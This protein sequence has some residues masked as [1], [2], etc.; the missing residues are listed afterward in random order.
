MSKK[1]GANKD[2]L[3]H[4]HKIFLKLGRK[5]FANHGYAGAST[6][7]IVEA[8]GMARGSLYY[9]FEDKKGLFIAVFGDVL[10]EMERKILRSMVGIADPWQ[11]IKTGCSTYI[12][13]C[14]KKDVRR[15]LLESHAA[16]DYRE[17][18]HI[19]KSIL[20][21]TLH[22][23]V[24]KALEAGYFKGNDPQIVTLLVFGMVS[25][26]GRSLEIADNPKAYRDHVTAS[27]MMFLEKMA[28]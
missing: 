4:T 1:P 12:D 26:A 28:S 17:R 15:I 8:S 7:R 11:A 13:L 19:Q 3:E 22:A 2:N 25:E 10:R 9:H 21:G 20:L 18:L 16:L 23:H 24:L 14:M 6:S 27:C 5:E